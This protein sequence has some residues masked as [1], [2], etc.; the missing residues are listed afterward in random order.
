MEGGEG[1]HRIL[2]RD[3]GQSEVFWITVVG[4][5]I[6]KSLQR[7]K[8]PG[9]LPASSSKR[10]AGKQLLLFPTDENKKKKI[11]HK[12]SFSSETSVFLRLLIVAS[13][14]TAHGDKGF[15]SDGVM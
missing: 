7:C 8:R 11:I 6:E 14:Y 13:I 5:L 9:E 4:F 12:A 1:G 3:V 2:Y 10:P 15:P